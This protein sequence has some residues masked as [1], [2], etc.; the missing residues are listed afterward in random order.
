VEPTLSVPLTVGNCVFTGTTAAAKLGRLAITII[1]S[2]AAVPKVIA[3][4]LLSIVVFICFIV[5]G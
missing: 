2:F 5:Y 3:K 1:A 4:V